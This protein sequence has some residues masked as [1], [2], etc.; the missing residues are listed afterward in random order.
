MKHV[1]VIVKQKEITRSAAMDRV[2]YLDL[3]VCQV[4]YDERFARARALR[5]LLQSATL[6]FFPTPLAKAGRTT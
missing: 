5:A 6:G 1:Q 3:C 2:T 4:G